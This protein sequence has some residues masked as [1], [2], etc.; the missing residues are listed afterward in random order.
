MKRVKEVRGLKCPNHDYVRDNYHF[1]MRRPISEHDLCQVQDVLSVV[2]QCHCI[3]HRSIN[4]ITLYH[5][6]DFNTIGWLLADS[7]VPG[8]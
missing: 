1:C 4:H 3:N 5:Y 7:L 8:S 2:T 6:D